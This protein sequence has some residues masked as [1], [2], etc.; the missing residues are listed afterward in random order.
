MN[1]GNTPGQTTVLRLEARKSFVLGVL[2]CDPRARPVDLTGCTLTIVA[3]RAPVTGPD[4]ETNLF[5]ADAVAEV[6][7]PEDG[8]ARFSIQASSLDVEPG[9]YPYAI[10]LRTA[11][12]YSSVIVKGVLDVQQNTEFDSV[13]FPFTG[14]NAPQ[15][16]SVLLSDRNIVRVTIGGQLP[17]G[18]NYVSDS[19]VK[20]LEDFD[21]DSIAYVPPGGL[22]GY[23]LTKVSGGDYAMAWRPKENGDG[24]L[25][26]TGV[27]AGAVPTAVGDDTWDWAHVGID[28]T[29]VP[30]GWA[31]VADGVGGWNWAQ[32][33]IEIPQPNWAEEDTESRAFIQNKPEL[34]TAAAADTDD[35][36][37][38]GTL[39]LQMPG[40]HI[41]SSVPTTGEDGHLYLVYTP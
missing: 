28:A 10:V 39:L 33:A 34:G 1:L 18:M 9:E 22:A 32:V 2:I 12:G 23:V 19:V 13:G 36:V 7:N 5:A 27:A 14:V 3:K 38:A 41:R 25:D 11:E 16:L 20:A 29:G 26:A 35:F 24:G 8:Y 6:E 15:T 30:E 31:P 4:E 17:P 40:V 21:P 37:P